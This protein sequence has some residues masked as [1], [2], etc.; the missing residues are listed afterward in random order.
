[1]QCLVSLCFPFTLLRLD[2][3]FLASFYV[4]VSCL[5]LL[6]LALPCSALCCQ[7][8]GDLLAYAAEQNIPVSSTPKVKLRRGSIMVVAAHF[9]SVDV[10]RESSISRNSEGQ[11][12]DK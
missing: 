6:C 5:A 8:R 11:R 7:G 10:L 3:F 2:F 12:S 4:I 1:M 9:L